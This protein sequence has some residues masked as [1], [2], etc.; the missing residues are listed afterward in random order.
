MPTSILALATTLHLAILVLLRHRSR[1]GGPLLLLP[2]A[3]L[4]AAPW[5]AP[6]PVWL[7]SGLALHA[8]WF[9]LSGRLFAGAGS[10][11]ASPRAEAGGRAGASAASA[12]PAPP[13]P[14]RRQGFE[15]ATVLAVVDETREIRTFRLRRPEG[16]TF[17]PGQFLMVRVLLDGKPVV[18][19]YSI[20]SA[21]EATGYLEIS[22]KR[23]GLVSG[24]LHATV[25]PGSA[26]EVKGPAGS[27]TYP[28]DDA[29]PLV[30]LAGGVGITPLVSMLRHA[31]AAEPTRPVTLLYSVKGPEDVAFA[32]EL[33][34]VARRHPQVRLAVTFTARAPEGALSG[35]I[36]GALVSR[37]VPDPAGAVYCVCGPLPMIE[38]SRALLSSLGV[39]AAQVR[40]EAFEA[41]V[42]AAATAP[43][44]KADT[45]MGQALRVEFTRSGRSAVAAPGRSLLEVAEEAGVEVPS[46]CRAGACGTC[47]SRLVNG[48]V[49]FPD[50]LLDP[51]ERREG[52]I[53]PCVA[54]PLTGCAL[55]A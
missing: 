48:E 36:D 49:D 13:A 27:F 28:G 7:L 45:G 35:R 30:L 47:K 6:E 15:P 32:D 33:R 37:H 31:V 11:A 44:R 42:A 55:D 26:L 34:S 17:V 18:R 41:A 25:R 16:F 52:W 24:A 40:A 46:L 54:R 9:V 39:P 2:S 4:A 14:A 29:R 1:R 50:D 5:V 12:R 8:G 19:C 51:G 3:G 22:V 10:P 38:A 23:Q 43:V 21:P 53:L 20:S